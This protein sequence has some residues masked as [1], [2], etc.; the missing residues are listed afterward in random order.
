MKLRK[1]RE[2]SSITKKRGCYQ[3]FTSQQKAIIGNYTLI[4]GPSVAVHHYVGEF[5]GL[6]YTIACDWRKGIS[7]NN[8]RNMI[9]QQ[10]YMVRKEDS[11]QHFLKK[12]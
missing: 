3:K 2:S 7:F 9:Q 11:H 8:K 5:P 12:L 6:K 10:N 4:N 1:L